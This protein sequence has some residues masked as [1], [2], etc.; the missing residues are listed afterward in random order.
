MSSKRSATLLAVVVIGVL[1]VTAAVSSRTADQQLV[2]Q[3]GS[4]VKAYLTLAE[5]EGGVTER[6][7]ANSIEVLDFNWGLENAVPRAGAQMV[8]GVGAEF[9]DLVIS[10][11]LDKASP[12]LA[13]AAAEG[14]MIQEAELVFY[15]QASD[16]Q[17]TGTIRLT[18]VRIRSVES[19]TGSA[20]GLTETV[21]LSFSRVQWTIYHTDERGGRASVVAGW[22][23]AENR[24]Y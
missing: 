14:R 23:V 20:A 9:Q 8:A 11:P 16:D 22:D 13:L 6:E 17:P 2:L 3:T 24:G 7:H 19:G 5:I 21:S 4:T 15:A 10:K 12:I 18:R 1:V